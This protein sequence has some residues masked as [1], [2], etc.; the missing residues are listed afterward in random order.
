MTIWRSSFWKT[1]AECK[2]ESCGW[3]TPCREGTDWLVKIFNRIAEGGGRPEDAQLILDLVDN[4]EGKSF[5]AL[6]DA[7]AW[8]IQGAV[9]RFPE[10]FK[11]YLLGK[12][13]TSVE[14]EARK[15]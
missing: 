8:A 11:P 9:K 4:I 5:C 15:F 6:G 14:P 3:C 7:A 2:H 12:K 10:D 1:A 13:T